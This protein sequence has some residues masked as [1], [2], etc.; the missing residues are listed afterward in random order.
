MQRLRAKEM[1][2]I[3]FLDLGKAIELAK[4]GEGDRW[5]IAQL[6]SVCDILNAENSEASEKEGTEIENT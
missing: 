6:K 4:P 1:R 5:S 3:G 2:K